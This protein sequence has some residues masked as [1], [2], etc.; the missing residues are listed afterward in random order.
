MLWPPKQK[1]III[2]FY[3]SERKFEMVDVFYGCWWDYGRYIPC[4]WE[5]NMFPDCYIVGIQLK[6]LKGILKNYSK[7]N[8][9]SRGIA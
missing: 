2:Q 5:V 4:G 8:L 7:G 6:K 3:P 9:S 1:I